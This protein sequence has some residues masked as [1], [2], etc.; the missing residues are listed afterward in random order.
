M[1]KILIFICLAFLAACA[2]KSESNS[3]VTNSTVV[4]TSAAGSPAN[5]T[6]TNTANANKLLNSNTVV[7]PAENS[8]QRIAFS[9]GADWG[10]TNVTLAPGAARR[11]IVGA[12][13][14]QTMNVEV[15]SKDTSVNL[16][17]GKAETTEDFG[18][19]TAEL[20]SNGDYVFEVKNPTKKEIKTSVKVTIVGGKA[21]MT[22]ENQ[23]A[24]DGDQPESADDKEN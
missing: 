2:E 3:D 10:A 20:Q 17:K 23:G 4:A 13:N 21:D 22:G 1:N 18:F 19:L 14:G 15:S 5:A 24:D 12:K 7:K 6:A 16:I 8:P 9:K 11:F